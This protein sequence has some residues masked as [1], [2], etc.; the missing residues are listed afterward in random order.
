MWTNATSGQTYPTTRGTVDMFYISLRGVC[1]R[2]IPLSTHCHGLERSL[3]WAPVPPTPPPCQH[4]KSLG[5][6]CGAPES[7]QS[8]GFGTVLC[9]LLSS[10]SVSYSATVLEE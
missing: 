6:E 1:V 7:C 10:A 9:E 8:R 3:H 4:E 5:F 2:T